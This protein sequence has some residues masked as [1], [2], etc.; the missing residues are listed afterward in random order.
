MRYFLSLGSN[1]EDRKKNLG[2]A[3]D[4]LNKAGVHIISTSS[5]YETEP[6]GFVNESWFYNQVLEIETGFCPEELL[7][8]LKRIEKQMGRLHTESLSSRPIDIDILLA[9]KKTVDAK[10]LQIPHPR[11][12][13]RNF[14]LFPLAEIAPDANHPV[15]NAKIKEL[16]KKSKDRSCVKKI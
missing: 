2:R 9:G 16:L 7:F 13:E 14:V 5:V 10:N 4:L 12:G 11:M 1:M 15:L 3:V 8:Q 6:V